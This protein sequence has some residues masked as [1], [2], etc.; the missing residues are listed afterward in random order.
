MANIT[1]CDQQGTITVTGNRYV[2]KA[3]GDD[4]SCPATPG[5]GAMMKEAAGVEPVTAPRKG[6]VLTITGHS[7][8]TERQGMSDDEARHIRTSL[9]V[10]PSPDARNRP[11][12]KMETERLVRRFV[13]DI[14]LCR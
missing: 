8:D 2:I 5:F 6:G 3:M 11:H 13:A 10:E 7:S 12:M 1:Q 14:L 9:R 4:T